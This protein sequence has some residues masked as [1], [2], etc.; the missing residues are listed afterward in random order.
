MLVDMV[1]TV[2]GLFQ[3]CWLVYM[4]DFTC[5]WCLWSGYQVGLVWNKHPAIPSKNLALFMLFRPSFKSVRKI[6]LALM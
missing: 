2:A 5:R 3:V 4:E 6:H 1:V